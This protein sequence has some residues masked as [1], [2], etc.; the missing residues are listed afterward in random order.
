MILLEYIFL[1]FIGILC[2]F[3]WEYCSLIK[4]NLSNIIK[5]LRQNGEKE[6]FQMHDYRINTNSQCTVFFLVLKIIQHSQWGEKKRI[7]T[8][9]VASKNEIWRGEYSF[10]Y[11]WPNGFYIMQ[12]F[13][14]LPIIIF[15]LLK[16]HTSK[17]FLYF[18]LHFVSDFEV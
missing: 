1:F 13:S 3:A 7:Y 12:H 5:K 8:F 15:N 6:S 18:Y 2:A 11:F 4:T 9:H 10:E 14:L 17:K 16:Y